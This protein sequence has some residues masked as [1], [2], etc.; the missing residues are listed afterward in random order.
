MGMNPERLI[1]VLRFPIVSEK[2]TKMA[3]NYRQ[4]AFKVLPDATKPEI[5]QAVEYLFNVKVKHVQTVRVKGKRKRFGRVMGQRNTWKKA[6][7]GLEEGYDIIFGA[8]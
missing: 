2:S 1:Q 3:D 6:Y 4:F 5:K 7:V 8:G